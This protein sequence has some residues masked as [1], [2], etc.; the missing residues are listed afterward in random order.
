MPRGASSGS[1]A[2]FEGE[3][4]DASKILL[5]NGWFVRVERAL[6]TLFEPGKAAV[7]RWKVHLPTATAEATAISPGLSVAS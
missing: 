1:A 4:P 6:Y 5:R 3:L 7:V 2:G